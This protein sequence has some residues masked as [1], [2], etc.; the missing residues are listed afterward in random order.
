MP[1]DGKKNLLKERGILKQKRDI[2][3]DDSP[4]REHSLEDIDIFG[5]STEVIN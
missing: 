4:S 2:L 1:K 5:S 3:M